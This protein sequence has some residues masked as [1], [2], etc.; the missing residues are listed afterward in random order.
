[1]RKTSVTGIR[2]RHISNTTLLFFF[3]TGFVKEEALRLLKTERIRLAP[4]LIK[5]VQRFKLRLKNTFMRVLKTYT[6]SHF[7][8]E[9][10]NT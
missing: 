7:L 6:R 2:L 4:R 1:M 5:N 8:L 3:L 10:K 9:R